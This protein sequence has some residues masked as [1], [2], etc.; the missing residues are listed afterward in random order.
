MDI[1]LLVSKNVNYIPKMHKNNAIR[2]KPWFLMYLP[3][4]GTSLLHVMTRCPYT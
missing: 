3:G 1:I 4:D 2:T